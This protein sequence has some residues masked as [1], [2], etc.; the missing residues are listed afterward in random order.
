MTSPAGLLQYFILE[1]SD[2]IEGLDGVLVRASATGPDATEVARLARM[3]RGSATMSR[4]GT[5][6]ELAGGVER[7]A[8]AL[9]EGAIR[10]EPA[11]S[12]VFVAAIDDLKLLV[13][14]VREW[15]EQQEA[16]AR[17]RIDEMARLAPPTVR[18]SPTP[19]QALG[20]GA[21]LAFE[22]GEISTAL[23]ALAT[24][25]L[26][27]SALGN[28]LARARALRGVAALRDLPPLPDV[29]DGIERAAKPLELGA[30][31]ATAAQLGLFHAA[32]ALLRQ[33]ADQMRRG[34]RPDADAPEVQ[35]FSAAAAALAAASTDAD[36]ILPISELYFGDA[37]PHVVSA[38]PHPPTTPAERFRLEVVS[39]AEH[40]R[41][42]VADARQAR[43]PA[44]RERLARELRG[45]LR[46]LGA[47]AESFG[48]RDLAAFVARSG[49][50]VGSLDAAA[51]GSLDQVAAILSRPSG[52]PGDLA[53]Q[54][55]AP[56]AAAAPAGPDRQA[57]P[58]PPAGGRSPTPTGRELHELLQ[59][60]IAG[61]DL[62]RER[63]LSQPVD[64]IDDPVVP[65][66]T[67]LYR[68]RAAL[69]RAREVR[70]GLRAGTG[71]PDPEALA[72]LYDLL[73]LALTD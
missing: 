18:A 49:E 56:A 14:Q 70:D 61:I 58:R 17:A 23:Q 4:Q 54:L 43:D 9:R 68:G 41:R 1:A 53:R 66:E 59:T 55:A 28:V 11:T 44:S 25:P 63:P 62:L 37:G 71:A 65:V 51:L 60:G 6:A 34:G 3:L 45:A 72:E 30:A 35:H 67:L 29:V 5:L 2:Y 31:Q 16:R 27:R 33:A 24:Q 26:D 40:L 47:A 52:N 73:D 22:A 32:S 48:E 36:A 20:S 69:D 10:W 64:I 42:L 39:Q 46:S 21:Y 57:P 19:P 13:R 38:A 8:R 50:A 15:G 12:A 7:M